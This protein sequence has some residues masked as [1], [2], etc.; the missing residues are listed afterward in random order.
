MRLT[1]NHT[2]QR[3]IIKT[4]SSDI[5]KCLHRVIPILQGQGEAG[6]RDAAIIESHRPQGRATG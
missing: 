5:N 6:E 1:F 4:Q 3:Q 2:K